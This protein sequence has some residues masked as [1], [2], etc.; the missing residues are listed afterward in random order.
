MSALKTLQTKIRQLEL[1]RTQ[2]E[3]NLKTLTA[4]T[5]LAH[6]ASRS[7][8]RAAHT[9]PPRSPTQYRGYAPFDSMT[10]RDAGQDIEFENRG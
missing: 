8:R 5:S 4:E 10:E 6:D 9:S 7:S 2:A 1:E 3:S